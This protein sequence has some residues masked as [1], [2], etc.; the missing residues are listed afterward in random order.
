VGNLTLNGE[1]GAGPLRYKEGRI[2]LF[3]GDA[4]EAQGAGDPG[5]GA[6]RYDASGNTVR[7]PRHEDLAYTHDHQVRYVRLAGGG[8]VRDFRHGNRRALRLAREGEAVALSIY[9]GHLE[10]HLRPGT[11]GLAKLVLHV[12]GQG[13]YGQV[14]RVLEGTDETSL[15]LFHHHPDHLGSGH[16]LTQPQGDLLSQE[17]Y[18]PY[19]GP[20]DRRDARNRY[21]YLGVERDEDTGLCMTGPRTYDPV[22]GRFLQGDPLAGG[23]TGH[24]SPYAYASGNPVARADP[25]GYQDV[26]EPDLGLEGDPGAPMGPSLPL[27]GAPAG[28]DPALPAPQG[29][30]ISTGGGKVKFSTGVGPFFTLEPKSPILFTDNELEFGIVPFAVPGIGWEGSSVP[31]SI[32]TGGLMGSTGFGL[33][34]LGRAALPSLAQYGA[35]GQVQSAL[36]QA[37]YYRAFAFSG[38]NAALHARAA[39]LLN[40]QAAATVTGAGAGAGTAGASTFMG[41]LLMGG[42]S[43]LGFWG[44]AFTAGGAFGGWMGNEIGD[45][46]SSAM[47][48]QWGER[49]ALSVYR[50]YVESYGTHGGA[51]ILAWKM[52]TGNYALPEGVLQP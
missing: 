10:Y 46:T 12:E 51:L 38:P 22:S 28:P 32:Q 52:G 33:T 45:Y 15:D 1:Y 43:K 25:S 3:N 49:G 11:P 27:A 39:M 34:W 16:L 18:F 5:A 6:F 31:S 42:V 17:E 37:A 23:A 8:E 19:G 24:V 30:G 26:C 50:H 7:T 40:S 2:D 29:P 9:T 14:E 21:R 20:S 35:T 36:V 41:R 4:A 13:R 48:Q 44:A 47:I